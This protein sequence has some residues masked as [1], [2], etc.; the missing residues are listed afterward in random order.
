MQPAKNKPEVVY[1]RRGQ[2]ALRS[3]EETAT[4]DLERRAFVRTIAPLIIGFLA[5][6]GLISFL[7]WRSANQMQQVGDNARTQGFQ[8]S[9]LQSLLLDLRLNISQVDSEARIRHT[10]LTQGGLATPFALRLDQARDEL[11]TTISELDHT[12]AFQD[13][14][15]TKLRTEL[16]R[17]VELSQNTKL[18]SLEGHDQFATVNK[19]IGE[20]F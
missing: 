1:R 4:A 7:G 12:A 10:T 9:R 18:Y 11:K 19:D 6:L 16:Q 15:W 5:L 14:G 3:P 2:P 17:Y 8:Y 20:L 13:P